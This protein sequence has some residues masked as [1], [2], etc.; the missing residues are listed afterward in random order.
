MSDP[1]IDS[2]R[3]LLDDAASVFADVEGVDGITQARA[4][5]DE[6]LRVAIA[7]KVKAGKST[8]LNALVGEKVAPTDTGECTRIVTWYQDGH[9]FRVMLHPADDIPPIQARFHR[10]DGAIEVDL[11][12]YSPAEVD[13]LE[14][15]WPTRSLAAITLIDTPGVDTLSDD[16]AGK[17]QEFLDP[18]DTE[19]P[20]DA[21]L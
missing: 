2:V 16:I 1:L 7:G 15:T 6:P 14:I 11:E 5:L 17:A 8:L 18:K 10:D 12:G 21:V 9:V 3:Q 19:T 4:R 20:A 13:K